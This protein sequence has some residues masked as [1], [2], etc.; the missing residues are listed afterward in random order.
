MFFTYPTISALVAHL[1]PAPVAETASAQTQ[2]A[3]DR[4]R[5]ASAQRLRRRGA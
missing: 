4:N 3:A 5:R 1:Q 2:S